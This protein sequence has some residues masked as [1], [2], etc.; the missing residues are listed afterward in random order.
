MAPPSKKAREEPPPP[1]SQSQP[2]PDEVTEHIF[3]RLPAR[4][5]A[6]CRCLSRSWA[7]ALSSRGFISRHLDAAG[8]LSFPAALS[9]WSREH[10]DTS[11]LTRSC[12]GLALVA[13][14]SEGVVYVGNPSTGQAASL[15]DGTP[16]A[17]ACLGLGYDARAG[18]RHKAVR[19][20]YQYHHGSG[21]EVYDV[22]G[23]GYW[24]PAAR[25][26]PCR[27]VAAGALG[28]PGVFARG[29]VHWLAASNAA[30]ASDEWELAARPTADSVMS[31]SAGDET[32]TSEPLPTGARGRPAYLLELTPLDGGRRLGLVYHRRGR[33][34]RNMWV[35]EDDGA[36]CGGVRWVAT[37]GDGGTDGH[38]YEESLEPVGRPHEDVVFASASVRALSLALRRLPARALGRVKSVSRSWRAVIDSERFAASHNDHHRRRAGQSVVVFT[39]CPPYHRLVAVQ[40]DSCLASDVLPPLMSSRVLVSKP[41]HGLA[42]VSHGEWG[43]LFNPVTRAHKNFFVG[44]S[45]GFDSPTT[46][47]FYNGSIGL[48]YDRSSRQHVLVLLSGGETPPLRRRRLQ[49][50]VWRL[51]E[52]YMARTVAAPPPVPAAVDVPPVYVE[53][54]GRIY[55][56]CRSPR[57][58]LAFN[59]RGEAFDVVPAPPDPAGGGGIS[60]EV[61]VELGGALRVVQSC[62][63][64]ETVTIWAAVAG[65]DGE[66]AREHVM[67]LGRWPEFSPKKT[68]GPVIPLAVDPDKDGGRILLD[69]G[70]S[71]GYYDPAHRTLETVYSLRSRP[72]LRG[73]GFF[74]AALWEESLVRPYDRCER[75]LRA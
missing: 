16:A 13:S 65:R 43:Q 27:V 52:E 75:F 67:Q 66:W 25:P 61:L 8:R 1:A 26:P 58:I 35:L 12:R 36:A 18:G 68:A 32:F 3:A 49:C 44:L 23:A 55:W 40:L 5:A 34:P 39:S 6:R 37:A 22:G 29:R 57:A 73:E 20:Y 19:V 4:S 14:I 15:P 63:S 17:F 69:T 53:D 30:A 70:R 50:S 48:G 59:I 2:L 38:L 60:T 11:P 45:F 72:E 62:P 74:A 31:F 33:R 21:C 42:M 54:D 64:T 7:A 28:A 9:A 47:D 24:R 71:L 10:G 46:T 56:M 51:R 41:C